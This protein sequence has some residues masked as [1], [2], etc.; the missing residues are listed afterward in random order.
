MQATPEIYPCPYCESADTYASNLRGGMTRCNGCGEYF[1]LDGP[2]EPE[3]Q[4]DYSDEQ[5]ERHRVPDR[6]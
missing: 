6:G 1:D 3:P 2:P 5:R 4:D